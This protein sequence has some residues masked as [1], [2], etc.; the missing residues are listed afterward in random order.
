M[1]KENTFREFLRPIK[2]EIIRKDKT[3]CELELSD[4]NN[5]FIEKR[6]NKFIINCTKHCFAMSV[7]ELDELSDMLKKLK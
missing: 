1:I 7:D 5:V 2:E 3:Y 6:N 4:G